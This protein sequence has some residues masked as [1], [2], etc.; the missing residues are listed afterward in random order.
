MQ[1]SVT[2]CSVHTERHCISKW[3]SLHDIICPVKIFYKISQCKQN[4][5]FLVHSAVSIPN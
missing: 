4:I 3:K 5:S 1:A 2:A